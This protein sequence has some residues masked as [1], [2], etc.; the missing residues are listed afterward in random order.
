MLRS[1]PHTL[2]QVQP[3]QLLRSTPKPLKPEPECSLQ[4]SNDWSCHKLCCPWYK[5]LSAI[6]D[7]NYFLLL[8][9][10]Q[11]AA[12]EGSFTHLICQIFMPD[13]LPD[14]TLEGFVSPG[15]N[16]KALPTSWDWQVNGYKLMEVSR[17]PVCPAS[18]RLTRTFPSRV[19]RL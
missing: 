5:L 8:P 1:L 3:I 2:I 12:T 16:W 4:K 17:L 15:L 18:S 14:A 7:K 11:R 6:S 10:S 9:Y 13:V 19:F